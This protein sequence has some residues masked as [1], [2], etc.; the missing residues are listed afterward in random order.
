MN[1]DLL[2]R[3]QPCADKE[4]VSLSNSSQLRV[5]KDAP[6]VYYFVNRQLFFEG[7]E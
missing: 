4:A 3:S 2:Q 1:P 6:H 5:L 7:T